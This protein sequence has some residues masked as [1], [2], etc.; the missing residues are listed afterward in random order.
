M[1]SKEFKPGDLV[2]KMQNKMKRLLLNNI[3]PAFILANIAIYTFLM[4][5]LILRLFGLI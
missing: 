4:S 2:E 5:L 1:R 3:H